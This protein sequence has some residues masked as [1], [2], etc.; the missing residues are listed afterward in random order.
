MSTKAAQQ[1][2]HSVQFTQ[3]SPS[4]LTLGKTKKMPQKTLFM[5]VRTAVE[6][7]SEIGYVTSIAASKNNGMVALINSPAPTALMYSCIKLN[8]STLMQMSVN[9]ATKPTA[10]RQNTYI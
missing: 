7:A 3:R 9:Q 6:V 2:P 8:G 4:P 5:V 10:L 1:A